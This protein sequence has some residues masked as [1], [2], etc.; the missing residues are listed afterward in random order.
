THSHI[1]FTNLNQLKMKF[2]FQKLTV[3]K[4]AKLFHKDAKALISEKTLTSYEKDQLRRASF[5]AVLN[6]TKLSGRCSKLYRRHFFE[7]IECVS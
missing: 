5:S 2:D 6:I 3:Y 4:K 7:K 1:L